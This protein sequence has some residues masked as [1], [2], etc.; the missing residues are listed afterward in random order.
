MSLL[1]YT[2]SCVFESPAVAD[3]WVAWLRQEHLAD[4]LAAGAM[5]AEI[6]RLDDPATRFEVR[7]HFRDRDA[8]ETYQRDHAPRLREAGL[9]LF[10]PGR[11][12]QYH[13]TTG[14][15]VLAISR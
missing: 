8:F 14:Q 5:D 9:R 7:Y 15:Q 3:E 10:P 2:V 6:V 13:R 4:V 11:G 1:V 12:V